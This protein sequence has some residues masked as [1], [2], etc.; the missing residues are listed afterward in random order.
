M[1]I[2]S[3]S[4]KGRLSTFL[5][6]SCLV[7]PLGDLNQ[8]LEDEVDLRKDL[9]TRGIGFFSLGHFFTGTLRNHPNQTVLVVVVGVN[10]ANMARGEGKKGR[11]RR[12]PGHRVVM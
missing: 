11:G 5:T 10:R 7:R 3:R 12:E 4:W 9:V 8:G 2:E 1:G 6:C